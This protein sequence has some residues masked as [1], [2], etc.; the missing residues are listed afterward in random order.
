MNSDFPELNVVTGASGYTGRY[1]TRRLLSLGKR[2]RTLTGHPDRPNPFGGQVS[3]ERFQFDDPARLTQ[4]LAGA[5][6]LYNTYWVRF[7][8]GQVTFEKAVENTNRLVK[9]AERAGVS[10]IVHLSVA[11]PSEGSPLPY[12]RG[13]ALAERAVRESRLSYAILRPTV[14]FG[15]GDILINNIAWLLRRFPLF[16]VLGSGEYRLQ[17][18]F[19][20]DVAEMAVNLAHQDENITVDAAGPEIYTFDELV[21]LIASKIHSRAKIL[22]VR[23][24]AALLLC[25]LVGTLVDDIVL[26]PEEAQGLMANLLVSDEPPRGTSQFS[27]WLE[28]NAESLGSGYA[29][30]LNRHFR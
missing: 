24:S 10:R 14:M 30:E 18:V 11:K 26:T 12:Y 23:P 22:H 20:E 25:R 9:A 7:P 2:V 17:P 1:I 5:R 3:V 15:T 28:L 16:A 6:T 21:R 29:S 4:S 19:V 13:K 27:T 8:Y